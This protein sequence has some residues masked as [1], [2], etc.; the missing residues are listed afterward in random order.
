V[1]PSFVGINFVYHILLLQYIAFFFWCSVSY[2]YPYHWCEKC[3][4]RF[5]MFH[6]T[7]FK[8][9]PKIYK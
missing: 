5:N 9:D 7:C 2:S 6:L 4:S 1:A 3:H 8:S